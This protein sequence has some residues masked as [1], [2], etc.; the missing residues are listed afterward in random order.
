MIIIHDYM[1]NITIIFDNGINTIAIT[2]WITL[3]MIATKSS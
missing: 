3:N 2:G 1:E